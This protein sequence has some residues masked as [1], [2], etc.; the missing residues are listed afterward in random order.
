MTLV[1]AVFFI[2]VTARI[3]FVPWERGVF[4]SED[5]LFVW[6]SEEGGGVW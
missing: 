1:Y 6:R 2:G 5:I 4:L 3:S